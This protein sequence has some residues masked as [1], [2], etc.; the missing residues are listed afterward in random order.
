[1]TFTS[2]Y[3]RDSNGNRLYVDLINVDNPTDWGHFKVVTMGHFTSGPSKGHTAVVKWT[4]QILPCGDDGSEIDVMTQLKLEVKTAH[5][6]LDIVTLFNNANI[7]DKKVHVI[8]LEIWRVSQTP[9][10]RQYLKDTLILVEPFLQWFEKYNSNKD[11]SDDSTEVGRAMQALS[12]FSYHVTKGQYLLCDVQGGYMMNTGEG[13]DEFTLTD[14][15]LLSRKCEFG[16]SDLGV[17]GMEAF[18]AAHK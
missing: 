16:M 15:A 7:W 14:P 9:H 6:A 17:R 1:M 5:K 4:Q 11:W 12:Y 2:V 18:F 13:E 8:I 3:T 10:V